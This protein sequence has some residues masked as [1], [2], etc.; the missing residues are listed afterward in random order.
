M[1]LFVKDRDFYNKVLKISI[2]VTIQNIIFISVN[3]I[4][5]MMLGSFG[6]TQ[7]SA[8]S[9]A[10]QF[11]VI[12]MI[13]CLGMGGGASVITAQYWGK[14]DIDRLKKAVTIM[15]RTML[16]VALFFTAV[17]VLFP[18]E[19]MSIYTTDAAIIEKGADFFKIGAFVYV[20]MGLSLT[21]TIILRSIGQLRVSLL[22][23]SCS[24]IINVFV[25][26]VFIFGKFGAPRLE[27]VG[28]AIGALT[29]RIFETLVVVG[30]L[31]LFDKRIK[32]RIRDFFAKC[33]EC[34]HEF[35]HYCVPVIISDLLLALGNN[36]VTVVMGRIGSEFVSAN[37]ITSI[38]VQ[39]S[40]VFIQGLSNASSII[41][42]NTL[43]KG[44]IP[45]AYH[46]GVTFLSLST[47]VGLLAGGVIVLISPLIISG[48]NI[49]ESTRLITVQL[50]NAVGINVVF[51]AISSVMTKGVLRGGGDTKFLMAADVLFLWI[52]SIP[53][54]ALAAFVFH[55]SPFWIFTLLKVDMIIKTFWCVFRLKSKKWIKIL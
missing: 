14:K 41:T 4:G 17:T 24:L 34:A 38:T 7:L 39:I 23:S 37:A 8:S 31:L 9:L 10:N 20:F 16:A 6:E 35:L 47:I 15:L 54:G 36:A 45:E 22:S 44:K 33:G 42:G 26:W 21:V 52:A 51:Q 11:Q 40:T 32:Y 13:L 55:L 46:Q 50:M 48:Y 49:T 30:Y 12:F 5:T 18:R 53:L 2:P 27:I 3:M 25:S 28:T 19:I 43:G 29:A 1:Q